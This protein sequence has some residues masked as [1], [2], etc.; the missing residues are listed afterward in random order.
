M[1]NGMRA[2]PSP[3]EAPVS[4]DSR[5]VTARELED[6]ERASRVLGLSPEVFQRMIDDVRRDA[7]QTGRKPRWVIEEI[8]DRM[9]RD[10][11]TR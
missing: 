5:L 10:Y 9:K 1:R 3:P 4:P 2:A 8:K 11:C 7:R 6:L